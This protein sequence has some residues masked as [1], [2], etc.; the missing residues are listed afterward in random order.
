MTFHRF[1]IGQT[2]AANGFG[3]PPGLYR[4]VRLLLLADGVPQYRAKS[5]VDEHERALAESV[6][7]LART[8]MATAVRPA[9]QKVRRK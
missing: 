9:E 5:M 3:I 2:V 1:T 7:R 4:I 6:L 8:A